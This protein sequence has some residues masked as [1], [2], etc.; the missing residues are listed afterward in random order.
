MIDAIVSAAAIPVENGGE[1][2]KIA[3]EV[4]ILSVGPST[5]PTVHQ[6]TLKHLFRTTVSV[7]FR[8]TTRARHTD[9]D[10]QTLVRIM[11][12]LSKGYEY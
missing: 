8:Q 7:T 5:D 12:M 10:I 3:I 2:R 9:E 4:K 6:V 11:M 1:I